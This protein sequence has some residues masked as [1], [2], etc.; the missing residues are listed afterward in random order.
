[1]QQEYIQVF[2]IRSGERWTFHICTGHPSPHPHLVNEQPQ[3]GGKRSG[4][5]S[6]FPRSLSE[7]TWLRG[8]WPTDRN[9]VAQF[10]SMFCWRSFSK[11][12]AKV[13]IQPSSRDT[14]WVERPMSMPRCSPNGYH[15][16][17]ELSQLGGYRMLGSSFSRMRSTW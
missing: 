12:T 2:M 16:R 3:I 14:T 9:G 10:T 1:M 4:L 8:A 7:E 17:T 15:I 11:I 5:L 13:S 6:P